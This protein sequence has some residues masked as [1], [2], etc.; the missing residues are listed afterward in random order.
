MKLI[1]YENPVSPFDA[2]FDRLNGS[3]PALDRAFA[4]GGNG[5]PATRLPR[6]NVQETEQAYVLTLEMP[7]LAKENVDVTFEE[8]T[9]IIKGAK[10]SETQDEKGVLRREYHSARFERSFNVKGIDRDQV[11]A[12]MDNGILVVTLPK[13][14][15]KAGRKID[16]A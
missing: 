7:G 13:T 15:A 6:T 5:S 16:V 11:Q 14:S 12:K 2:I 3:G 1:K 10:S 4:G 9:L 8:D